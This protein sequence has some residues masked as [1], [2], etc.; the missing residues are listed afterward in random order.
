MACFHRSRQE[1]TEYRIVIY[2]ATSDLSLSLSDHLKLLHDD[3]SAVYSDVDREGLQLTIIKC[4]SGL[5]GV[6]I[7]S[8]HACLYLG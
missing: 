2:D 8:W 6:D 1:R 4:F 5:V 7:V 3:C